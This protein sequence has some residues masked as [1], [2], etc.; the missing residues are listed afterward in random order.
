MLLEIPC[1]DIRYCSANDW[2][3]GA[4]VLTR[5]KCSYRITPFRPEHNS[6]RT[7]NTQ[8]HTLLVFCVC[9]IQKS[10]CLWKLHQSAY[11]IAFLFADCLNMQ[12]RTFSGAMT[13][14]TTF[15]TPLNMKP[16]SPFNLHNCR[17]LRFDKTIWKKRYFI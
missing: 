14:V 6:Y 4:H 5:W 7:K 11:Q 15:K 16:A 10:F 13:W 2:S 12:R 9:K 3:G 17:L 1:L 8:I